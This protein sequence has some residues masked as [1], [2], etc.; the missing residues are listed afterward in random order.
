MRYHA[1][2]GFA[3]REEPAKRRDVE[4]LTYGFR[5]ELGNWAVGTGAGVVMHDVGFAEPIVRLREQPSDAGRVR[6]IDGK[7]HS[8]GLTGQRRQ[9]VDIASRQSDPKT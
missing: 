3:D 1:P 7:G 9:L 6:R 4:G 5:V 8:P 2:C